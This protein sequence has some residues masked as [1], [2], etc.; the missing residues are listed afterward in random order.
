MKQS[1][2]QLFNL[3]DEVA[4]ILEED[5]PTQAREIDSNS[6]WIPAALTEADFTRWLPGA[7]AMPLCHLS[8]ASCLCPILKPQGLPNSAKLCLPGGLAGRGCLVVDNNGQWNP[9]GPT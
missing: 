2:T 1:Q 7:A 9:A 3:S 8:G 5:A 6:G 4:N